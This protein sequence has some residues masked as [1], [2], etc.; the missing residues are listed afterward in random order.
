MEMSHSVIDE[1]FSLSSEQG[2]CLGGAFWAWAHKTP[3]F[4]L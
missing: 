3:Y 2:Q 4:A 1:L